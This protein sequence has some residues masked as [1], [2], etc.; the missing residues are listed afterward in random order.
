MPLCVFIRWMA[1]V[2]L[3][4]WFT[5]SLCPIRRQRAIIWTVCHDVFVRL[6]AAIALPS[7]ISSSWNIH[8]QI[9][10]PQFLRSSTF[11]LILDV[12]ITQLYFVSSS[13]EKKWNEKGQWT[14]TF[15]LV[16]RF[17]TIFQMWN[18]DGQTVPL[19][20][21]RCVVDPHP[22]DL[23]LKFQFQINREKWHHYLKLEDTNSF[24]MKYST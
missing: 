19:G 16:L 4:M 23:V 5:V 17:K 14:F 6:L 8:W 10:P 11:G 18:V 1:V 20:L 24:Q 2:S 13:F 21:F 9:H 15:Y 3:F 22:L 12:T 7:L